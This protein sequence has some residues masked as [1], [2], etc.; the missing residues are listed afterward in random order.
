MYIES[1]YHTESHISDSPSKHQQQPGLDDDG[2]DR[3][4]DE[5]VFDVLFHGQRHPDGGRQLRLL[6]LQLWSH[7]GRLQ[8][9]ADVESARQRDEPDFMR[10]I[11]PRR[12]QYRIGYT[13]VHQWREF[14][15]SR[16]CS[17]QDDDGRNTGEIL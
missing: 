4:P 10:A 9:S 12:D 14:Q 13:G 5:D 7:G 8:E 1:Q 15:D 6:S 16:V 17:I 3:G 11:L 2:G